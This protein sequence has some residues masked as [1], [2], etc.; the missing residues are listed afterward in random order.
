MAKNLDK[1]RDE[2]FAQHPEALASALGCYKNIVPP[3]KKKKAR[4]RGT[5][6]EGSVKDDVNAFLDSIEA[7]PFMPSQTFRGKRAVDYLV[8]WRSIYIAIET[9]KPGVKKGTA[10]Q[11]E[12]L[13]QVR[14]HGGWAFLVNDIETFVREFADT[15]RSLS[16]E[17]PA[18]CFMTGNDL[19]TAVGRRAPAKSKED[20]SS[21]RTTSESPPVSPISSDF[22]GGEFPSRRR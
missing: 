8:C 2:L 7:F 1:E 16:I 21:F 13:K 17:I 22:T 20:W 6:P 5:T 18:I 12:F 10:S 19:L 4:R 15:C 9:K 3:V 14:D 11:E